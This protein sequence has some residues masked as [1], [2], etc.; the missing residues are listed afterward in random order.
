MDLKIDIPPPRDRNRNSSTW[1]SWDF[2]R[3]IS[4]FG[5]S[6][7]LSVPK[8]VDAEISYFDNSWHILWCGSLLSIYLW[9]FLE[10]YKHYTIDLPLAKDMSIIKIILF[11]C[12]SIFQFSIMLLGIVLIHP[13][14]RDL[15]HHKIHQLTGIL[16]ISMTL[17]TSICGC[18]FVITNCNLEVQ[19][20]TNLITNHVIAP[21]MGHIWFCITAIMTFWNIQCRRNVNKHKPWALRW[22]FMSLAPVMYQINGVV[23]SSVFA[24]EFEDYVHW[25][26]PNQPFNAWWCYLGGELLL[27]FAIWSK[28]F[29]GPQ[30]VWIVKRLRIRN[31]IMNLV[32]L[33]VYLWMV[34]PWI[35]TVIACY[36][37]DHFKV[38]CKCPLR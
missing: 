26:T 30:Q 35:V 11:Q 27:E 22:Y 24:I 23:I 21:L 7:A 8:D 9:S 29:C 1:K 31:W 12:T 33:V 4:P 15:F 5:R 17:I 36:G 20:I 6:I 37:G 32:A 13:A 25:L 14:V 38:H 34:A 18:A 10:Q 28:R 16:V 3:F 19:G 2:S